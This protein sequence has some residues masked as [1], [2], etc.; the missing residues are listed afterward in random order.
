MLLQWIMGTAPDPGNRAPVT[1]LNIIYAGVWVDPAEQVWSRTAVLWWSRL[2]VTHKLLL[3]K[4]QE[5]GRVYLLL[6]IH[7]LLIPLPLSYLVIMW[8]W[9]ICLK[10]LKVL[11]GAT[12]SRLMFFTLWTCCSVFSQVSEG[13]RSSSWSRPRCQPHPPVRPL[14]R[15][16]L[17]PRPLS[18]SP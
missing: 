15:S 7:F 1:T 14:P 6:L 3:L 18:G 2:S 16:T 13:S 4:M 9:W 11:F 12:S 8:F 10:Q 17:R 5:A